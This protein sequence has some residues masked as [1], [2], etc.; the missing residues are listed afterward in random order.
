MDIL[1]GG[2]A[3]G[4]DLN[5]LIIDDSEDDA[6]LIMRELTRTYNAIYVRVKNAAELSAALE[7]CKWDII[8]CDYI[9]PGFS[10]F[11][12]LDMLKKENIDLPFIVVSGK[13][14]EEI[15]IEVMKAGASD[16]IL[17]DKL[18][19]LVPV[20]RRE[21][22]EAELRLR[23]RKI[24]SELE[25]SDER[26]RD[27]CENANDM[28]FVSRLDG[29]ILYTNPS[30]QKRMGYTGPELLG[31]R[32]NDVISVESTG[33]W[34]SILDKLTSGGK[35]DDS[36]LSLISKKN[37]TV[38]AEG[39]CSV[40][41]AADGAAT[42]RGF[43]RDVTK[44]KLTE[45]MREKYKAIVN[46]SSELM[47]VVNSE[48]VY[49]A[50]ND[51][52]CAA[53][54]KKREEILGKT[55]P[56]LLGKKAFNTVI[57]EHTDNCLKGNKASFKEW[58]EFPAT[59]RRYHEVSLYPYPEGGKAVNAVIILDDITEVA[60][61]EAKHI[62]YIESLTFLSKA[63]MGFVELSP[64]NDIYRYIASC[65]N[66]LVPG[67][68]VVAGE[69]L[70]N[71][72]YVK[73]TSLV[74]TGENTKTVVD[75]AG[76]ALLNRR[77][78]PDPANRR[79]LCT[80]KLFKLEGGLN[81][82]SVRKMPEVSCRIIQKLFNETH[83]YE[84]GFSNKG[85]LFG[86][87][88]LILDH[89][90]APDK[91]TV[92]ETFASQASVALLRRAAEKELKS[93]EEKLM[94]LYD[95]SPEAYA[96][97]D[98]G[99]RLVDCNRAFEKL[100]GYANKEVLGKDIMEMMRVGDKP[101]AKKHHE[102]TDGDGT[103]SVRDAYVI[104]IKDD[105]ELIAE[106]SEHPVRVDDAPHKLII[107]RDIT[108]RKR[109]VDEIRR[110]AK[111]VYE[112]PAPM[113]RI[114]RDGRLLYV[115]PSG[116]RV[117]NDLKLEI[118]KP[119]PA[120][121]YKIIEEVSGS[122]K[123]RNMEVK[124]KR[125]TFSFE[126]VPLTESGYVNLYGRDITE[127][128]N[129]ERA[130]RE[131]E[132]KYRTLFEESK[133]VI[134]IS[135][136]EG[137]CKDINRAGVELLGYTTKEEAMKIRIPDDLYVN[138]ADRE[139]VLD[140][141]TEYGYLKDFELLI[142]RQDGKALTVLV[143]S[144]LARNDAGEITEIRSIV[145]DLTE[146]RNMEIQLAQ[147]QKMESLG[148]LAGGVAHDF[149]NLLT[150]IIGNVSYLKTRLN[151]QKEFADD[152]N[153]IEE[154]AKHAAALTSQLLAFARGGKYHI[155]TLNINDIVAGTVKIISKTFSK[156]ISI[157]T[158]LDKDAKLVEADSLQMSQVV[159]NLCVNAR[160]AMKKGGKLRISTEN[161]S[162]AYEDARKSIEAKPGSYVCLTVSDSGTGMDKETSS[163][164]FEPFFTTKGITGGTGLGLS[165]VYG[166]VRNHGG[167][168]R[169]SSE[170]GKGSEFKVYFPASTKTKK[171]TLQQAREPLKGRGEMLLLVDD[172]K[173]I[174][175]LAKRVLENNGYKVLLAENGGEALKIFRKMSG[176]LS[177]VVLDMI[178][179]ETDSEEVFARMRAIK[180]DIKVL[181]S[182]GYSGNDKTDRMLKSGL[183][184]IIQK[185]YNVDV[186]LSYVRN[187]IDSKPVV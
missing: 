38:F 41:S 155:D 47:S 53:L 139:R 102:D 22:K 69:C 116:V 45:G 33:R 167:F 31:M 70:K 114:S 152:I 180:E 89:E 140:G 65:L 110:L 150:G 94:A 125:N 66:G 14:S 124:L 119:V 93:S 154:S 75:A 106:I 98:A 5:V 18:G 96:L 137:T 147:F 59:G 161:V 113:L 57:K 166:I 3:M 181:V 60:E 58:I 159:M 100:T 179:P 10:A 84:I 178:M 118:D 17:K 171:E 170:A 25:E 120:Q 90:P 1:A 50:V 136:P 15:T 40:K 80:G 151:D 108:E 143:T 145:K 187:T 71:I 153:G 9:I 49:E 24:T 64:E 62:Q 156:N 128:E 20:V 92:I 168:I 48:Y 133:D 126:V 97:S 184:G 142:K 130:L 52:Y 123:K 117:L 21:L 77:Y 68:V 83:I 105:R 26:Y 72:P 8:I 149:N 6:V 112:S 131:S 122:G 51:A 85:E 4:M 148:I 157:D 32:I 176:E 107:I 138:K 183:K 91:K 67:S 163:R 162:L 165:V 2:K 177:L 134:F 54:G 101:A 99:G 16:Y 37:G 109:F 175:L 173:E 73:I 127:R 103:D 146:R 135:T 115:N 88:V 144:N 12:A 46:A 44:G 104:K 56:D 174:R 42:I 132:E 182:T 111:F 129:S 23:N 158:C 76:R 35:A 121:W 7:R 141:L 81:E 79:S 61:T 185:P 11:A 30:F 78:V 19:R 87:A 160:D 43:L 86:N 55:M 95:S 169:V 36:E 74:G 39:V 13:V 34:N 28:I 63:A 164:I 29:G 27:I 186:L 82:L 172:E